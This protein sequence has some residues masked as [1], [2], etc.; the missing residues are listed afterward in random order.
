V[1]RLVEVNNRVPATYLL[2][3]GATAEG[4]AAALAAGGVQAVAIGEG[5]ESVRLGEGSLPADAL[6][7]MP[8][9]IVQDP[10]SSLVARYADIPPGTKVAD[11]CAAPGGKALAVADRALYT[12]AADRSE[13]RLLM[14]KE[15]ARRVGRPLGLVVADA[16]QPPL[17][18]VD[19]VLLDAPCSGTGTLAR[20]PDARWRLRPQSVREL[21]DVQR[22]MLH[23]SAE[24][25]DAGGL[26]V[27][28]TCSL[29]AEEN[30]GQVEAFLASRAD[31]RLE[32]TDAVP[33]KY[34]DSAGRLFV[35]PQ[36]TG[37]DGAFAARLRKTG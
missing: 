21:V 3:L 20:R 24:L 29:E 10:A 30:E 2:A 15:N 25:L 18:G 22:Q 11:L 4:A 31:F 13:S 1:R 12:L 26:L 19:V 7:V 6:A 35:T 28:S 27:Y 5:T 33:A 17:S 32:S 14:V 23:A 9:A 34:L 8:R 16:R 36:D 37:F